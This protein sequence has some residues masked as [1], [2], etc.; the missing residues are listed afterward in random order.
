MRPTLEP[1]ACYRT[2]HFARWDSNPARLVGRLV[3]QGQLQRLR[4]GLY[5]CPRR[6][7]FGEVPP[8]DDALLDAFLGGGPHVVTG[9]ERWNALQ[10]GTTAMHALPL[11]YNTKVS[12]EYLLGRRRFRFRRVTFPTD[13]TPEWYVVDLLRNLDYVGGDR[14]VVTARLRSR[15]Q[16]G[17]LDPAA[18]WE[19]ARAYGRR[20]EQAVVRGALR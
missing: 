15:V 12:G 14:Q 2:Q 10:L 18:L 3:E 13:P 1:G 9:P 17:A 4:H 6:S 11:V 16:A 20:S 5:Y 19:A 8:S 7:R